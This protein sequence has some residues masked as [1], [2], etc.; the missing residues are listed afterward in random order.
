MEM[1]RHQAVA[2]RTAMQ[3]IVVDDSEIIRVAI[4]GAGP[5]I[6]FIH[7]W[8]S[9]HQIWERIAWRM[10]PSFQVLRWDARGHGGHPRRSRT[11]LTVARMA[12]DLA[13]VLDRFQLDRPVIVAHSMGALILW[14]MIARHGCG[15]LGS[16]VVIDMT[17]KTVTDAG[18]RLGVY[19]D[20][21]RER[22]AAFAQAMR[23]DF[24]EAVIR[25]LSLSCNA[26]AI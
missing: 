2:G 9:S 20:W 7:E 21:S 8:A 12:D 4:Q 1:T 18:W 23:A 11:P 19:G 5:P 22:N 3:E 13:F 26:E 17:P 6:L 25:F 10:A 14:E 15:A 16:I 24:V